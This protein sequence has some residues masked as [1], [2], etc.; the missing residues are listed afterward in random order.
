MPQ[1]EPKAP[2]VR[3]RDSAFT[4]MMDMVVAMLPLYFM[5]FY[6]YGSRARMLGLVSTWFA[7]CWRGKSLI[8]GISLRWSPVCFCH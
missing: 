4:I 2:Y 3:N 1:Y 5:A 8:F 6:F 7:F